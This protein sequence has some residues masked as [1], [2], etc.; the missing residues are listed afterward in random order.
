[1][2]SEWFGKWPKGQGEWGK[3]D[4]GEGAPPCGSLARLRRATP[5]TGEGLLWL[6][7]D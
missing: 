3:M 4:K 7:D 1:M 2:D 5:A 6:N